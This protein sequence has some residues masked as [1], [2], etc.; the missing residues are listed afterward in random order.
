MLRQQHSKPDWRFVRLVVESPD[1]DPLPGDPVAPGG[2]VVGYV[3]SGATGFRTEKVVA[4]GY[5]KA[6]IP[7]ETTR[8]EIEVLGHGCAAYLHE[9]AIY[10][11]DNTRCRS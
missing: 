4:L 2:E 8:F 3:T 7:A 9:H 1:A 11:P 5:I 10:D 6:D